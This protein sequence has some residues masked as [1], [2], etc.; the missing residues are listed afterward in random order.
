M[1][2]LLLKEKL[3]QILFKNQLSQDEIEILDDQTDFLIQPF[4][5]PEQKFCFLNNI[6]Q[7]PKCPICNNIL[8]VKDVKKGFQTFCSIRCRRSDLGK[9]L[10]NEKTKEYNL[11]K[12]GVKWV[13]QNS[14][15]KERKK[16]SNLEKYG[17]ENVFQT[18]EVKE[19][20]IKT[21]L[22]KYK[23]KSFSQTEEYKE[24]TKKTLQEKYK[25]NHVWEKNSSSRIKCEI[26]N[27]KK[28]GV[29][30]AMQND[31][32]QTKMK[33]TQRKNYWE[34]FNL[35]LN[36]KFISPLFSKEDYLKY[37]SQEF[38]CNKCNQIFQSNQVNPQNICCPF[39]KKSISNYEMEI[40]EWIKS[41]NLSTQIIFNFRQKY[42]IDIYLPDYNLGIEF[43]G[44]YWHSE[45][46]KHRNYHQEKWQFFKDKNIQIIQIFEHEWILK[47]WIIKS[48]IKNKLSLN[49]K[50]FAR[51]CEIREISNK[52]FSSFLEINHLQGN[53]YSLTK[54]GLFYQDELVQVMSFG[55][56]RFNKNY[57]W[58]NIRTCT[59]CDYHIVGGFN[60]LLQYFIRNYNPQSIISYVDL[61]YF[62]GRGYLKNGFI[63]KSISEP[64]YY[65]WK[66]N[67]L[68]V[69]IRN[70]FQK[71]LLSKKL[72]NFNDKLSESENMHNHNYFRIYDAG[73]IVLTFH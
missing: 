67:S 63:Q 16:N 38:L 39:C 69:F 58:E 48:I 22:K 59:K 21:N 12:Y 51:K 11:E 54:I 62:D 25:V 23:K 53:A 72:S 31:K 10:L 28:Y 15:I 45:L 64:R 55:K 5:F 33:Q 29:K 32:I 8:R 1:N 3:K 49:E 44:L 34:I 24:K 26:T 52:D 65:W 43:H 46:H 18:E 6:L 66:L 68:N 42:E 73:N 70:Q 60:K 37:L 61:R 41:L 30:N 13:Q 20:I 47:P 36:K 14:E 17:V 50:L 40:R 4:H 19:K 9:K 27:L 57:E 56:S 71:K 2:E 35:L 7:Y